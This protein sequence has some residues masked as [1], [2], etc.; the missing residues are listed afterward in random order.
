MGTH[1]SPAGDEA[2]RSA[3]HLTKVVFQA[4]N[5]DG[6][7]GA[8]LPA[9]FQ[10][11]LDSR[12]DQNAIVATEGLPL[13]EFIDGAYDIGYVDYRT[14]NRLPMIERQDGKYVKSLL[15]AVWS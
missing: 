14:I 2:L 4:G 9:R 5:G 6:V 8:P 1:R 15:T 7:V 12:T 3:T 13:Q 11:D 10:L